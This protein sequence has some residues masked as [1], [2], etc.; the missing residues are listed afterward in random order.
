M[1]T[2][3]RTD[4]FSLRDQDGV[5][6]DMQLNSGDVGVAADGTGFLHQVDGAGASI[7]KS[8]LNASFTPIND[9]GTIV[10]EMDFMI[11]DGSPVHEIYLADFESANAN[12]GTHPGVRVYLH[13][14]MLRVDRGK[15]GEDMWYG[16]NEP[17]QTGQW[18]TQRIELVAGDDGA[19]SVRIFLDGELVLD[20]AGST[21]LTQEV[22]QQYGWSLE[23]GELDRVQVG[24]TANNGSSEASLAT[25]DISVEVTD[26]AAGLSMDFQP[27]PG[28]L[29]QGAESPVE[30]LGPDVSFADAGTVGPSITLAL[31]DCAI[32]AA[33]RTA[34]G[35]AVKG[36]KI[37]ATVTEKAA[38]ADEVDFVFVPA[39]AGDG[40]DSAANT[41]ILDM[42]AE[43]LAAR[44]IS[45]GEGWTGAD[46]GGDAAL[47]D[48][49]TGDSVPDA[50][51]A[52]FMAHQAEM[53]L[54]L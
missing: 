32:P 41:A 38:D 40:A 16:Q 29:V 14:G 21:V 46:G 4:V 26:P 7:T 50:F 24:L 9:G 39:A 19:G 10:L 1:P 35:G 3:Y 48:A 20:A 31:R 36:E 33:S 30:V 52:L 49:D 25:R 42:E 6:F 27:D 47:P 34:D 15:I 13:E 28:F 17:I 44:A 23:G 8:T 5:K 2:N 11:P 37:T 51:D 12:T 54:T 18:Y 45:G 53:D 22:A 43:L